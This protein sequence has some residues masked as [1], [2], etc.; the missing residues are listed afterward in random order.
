MVLG[1]GLRFDRA[2][3][4]GL[5]SAPGPESRQAVFTSSQTTSIYSLT[6]SGRCSIFAN[7]R[8][9]Q[10]QLCGSHQKASRCALRGICAGNVTRQGWCSAMK[11][12][13]DFIGPVHLIDEEENRG[14]LINKR[15]YLSM[16]DV[17]A[18]EATYEEITPGFVLQYSDWTFVPSDVSRPSILFFESRQ[19]AEKYA[20]GSPIHVHLLEARLYQINRKRKP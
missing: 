14:Q 2:I 12:V 15:K 9:S 17:S 11:V 4:V 16:R 13:W 18:L 8:P 6:R 5:R 19:T 10:F 3:E 7:A 20:R 1:V